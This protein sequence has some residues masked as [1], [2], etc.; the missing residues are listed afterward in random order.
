MAT[1]GV[2]MRSSIDVAMGGTVAE[3][4]AFGQDRVGIGAT[5]DL[6]Q[7]TRTARFLVCDCGFSDVIGPMQVDSHSSPGRRELADREVRDIVALPWHL[8][9][10]TRKCCA[11][12]LVSAVPYA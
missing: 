7:A 12:N 10:V 3:R 9:P 6:E 1:R 2:Q 5:S 4:L 8:V 11:F